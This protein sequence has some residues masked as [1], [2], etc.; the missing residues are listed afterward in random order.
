MIQETPTKVKDEDKAMLVLSYLGI[1]CLIPYFTVKKE[2]E[3]VRWHAR[4]GIILL[5]AEVV[6]WLA[7]MILSAIIAF[8][9]FLF[10]F[11]SLLWFVYIVGFLALSIYGIVQ[12]LKGLK[13]KIPFLGDFIEKIPA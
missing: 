1:L 5:I 11:M 9:P 7:L 4:Q 8:V 13:W 3:Y 12:S 6:L 2:N 10:F